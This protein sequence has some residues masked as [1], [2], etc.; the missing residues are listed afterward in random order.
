MS[1]CQHGLALLF[2][3]PL[4]P[5]FK[6]VV[7]G[8]ASVTPSVLEKGTLLKENRR[9]KASPEGTRRH[10]TTTNKKLFQFYCGNPAMASYVYFVFAVH[11]VT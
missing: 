4:T 10:M 7:K 5:I 3:L 11:S 6:V 8:L 1:V 2:Q 9:S